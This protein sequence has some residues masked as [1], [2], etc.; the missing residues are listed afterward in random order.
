MQHMDEGQLQAWLDR[1]RSGLTDEERDVIARH[2][3][4]CPAC[5]A[6]VEELEEATHRLDVLMA[7]AELPDDQVPA[8]D[9]VVARAR[10]LRTERRRRR[11]WL[12]G[13]WAASVVLAIGVG[14][15][16]NDMIRRGDVPV[17]PPAR[18]ASAGT[19][20]PGEADDAAP[21][22]EREVVEPAAPAV[23]RPERSEATERL[24]LGDARA[25]TSGLVIRGRVTD[26]EGRPLEAAQV[27]T[28]DG[29]GALSRA[30]G[31]FEF[32][33][34][35]RLAGGDSSVTVQ[36]QLLGY[37]REQ[38]DL[39]LGRGRAVSTEFQL[40]PSAISL[41][42]LVVTGTPAPE[43]AERARPAAAA[44]LMGAPAV[45]APGRWRTLS[46]DD[47]T[48]LAGFRPLTLDGLEVTEVAI[49]TTDDEPVVRVTQVLTTG[50][51]VVLLQAL[52]PV[53]AAPES[54]ETTIGTTTTI[55]TT[56]VGDIHVA[57]L[58]PVDAETLRRLLSDLR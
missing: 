51:R 29:A 54:A 31:T 46:I 13:G 34:P 49:D 36:A 24:A 55:E 11:P 4:A 45:P 37:A 53:D 52:S 27:S 5:R 48:V 50:E 47:A 7:P 33:L 42:E 57:A 6:R 58:A 41:S 39:P 26:P 16:G 8:F 40:S 28:S 17:A 22:E 43:S 18:T 9:E 3:E 10:A 19:D 35:N 23:A 2:L 1:P 15:L 38:R 14:W 30:D 56:T 44:D 12:A 25:D 32:A 20:G 21:R